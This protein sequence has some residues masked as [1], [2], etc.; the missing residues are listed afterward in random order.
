MGTA[1]VEGDKEHN[2]KS[3]ASRRM[4]KQNEWNVM[5]PAFAKRVAHY[6]GETTSS[7]NVKV[8]QVHSKIIRSFEIA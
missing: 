3:S 6:H 8:G 2:G 5:V 4:A 7:Q 1:I